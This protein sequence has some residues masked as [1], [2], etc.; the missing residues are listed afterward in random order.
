M[1]GAVVAAAI[2]TPSL[3][4]QAKHGWAMLEMSRSL[5]REHS[6]LG[7][8]MAFLPLQFLLMN[9]VTAPV[10][11]FGLLRLWRDASRYRPVAIAFVVVALTIAVEPLVRW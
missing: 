1:V 10:W 3:A 8:G 7:V 6:G 5:R 4:W 9:P 2:W 11:L